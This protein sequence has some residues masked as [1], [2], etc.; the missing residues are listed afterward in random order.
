MISNMPD[1]A[2][3]IVENDKEMS[4][5]M[6]TGDDSKKSA[7]TMAGIIFKNKS[8]DKNY[9]G[10]E[11]DISYREG[12]IMSNGRRDK[13]FMPYGVAEWYLRLLQKSNAIKGKTSRDG[14]PV[15]EKNIDQLKLIPIRKLLDMYNINEKDIEEIISEAHFPS[16]D[17]YLEYQD[18]IFYHLI[19]IR[20]I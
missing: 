10:G 11:D 20:Q 4:L 9:Q 14:V 16:L 19:A 15:T 13:K 3:K 5:V 17:K 6:S 7:K 18:Q 1:E 12:L 2:R 8:L